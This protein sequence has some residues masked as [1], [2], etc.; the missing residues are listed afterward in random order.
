MWLD[1]SHRLSAMMVYGALAW[2]WLG[3]NVSAITSACAI[4][5]VGINLVTAYLKLR[6]DRRERA[7]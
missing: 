4:L 1:L 2:E 5:G 3:Q 6:R 7:D